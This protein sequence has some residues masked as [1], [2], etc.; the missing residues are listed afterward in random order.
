VTSTAD[1]AQTARC[2]LRNID[3]R[4]V[5]APRPNLDSDQLGVTMHLTEK[6]VNGR[7]TKKHETILKSVLN[8]HNFSREPSFA[9]AK[10]G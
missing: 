10:A 4:K 5:G 2:L 8:G 1:V 6:S 7:L 9:G 3:K